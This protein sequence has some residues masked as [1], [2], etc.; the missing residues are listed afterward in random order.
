MLTARLHHLKEVSTR[1]IFARAKKN[2][3]ICLVGRIKSSEIQ[4]LVKQL[5]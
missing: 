1:M 2:G 4:A 5:Y 3:K